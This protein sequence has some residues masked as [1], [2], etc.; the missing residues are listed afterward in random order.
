MNGKCSSRT[1]SF[2]MR[3]VLAILVALAILAGSPPAEAQSRRGGSSRHSS[4]GHSSRFGLWRSR[5]AD[6]IGRRTGRDIDLRGEGW[7]EP[8]PE[9]EKPEKGQ[10]R[11]RFVKW[12][13]GKDGRYDAL[14]IVLTDPEGKRTSELVVPNTGKVKPGQISPP[15]NIVDLAAKLK[16]GDEVAV[17]YTYFKRKY[18]VDSV[19]LHSALSAGDNAPFTFVRATEVKQGD[20][21]FLGVT[22]KR[23]KLIWTFLVPNEDVSAASFSG[24]DGKPLGEGT[25]NAPATRMLECLATVRNG[26]TISL[27]YSPDSYTFVLSD[28]RVSKIRSSGKF[29]RLSVRTVDGK[30]H[31]MAM[32]RVGTRTLSLVLP[33]SDPKKPNDNAARMAALLK[34]MR[35]WREVNFTYRRQ[36]GESWLDNVTIKP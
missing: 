36:D 1:K 13:K 10:A 11:A 14:S 32:F 4:R 31:Q 29:E 12:D 28:L 7:Q 15:A 20:R 9:P 3:A 34:D 35:Q 27:Q 22:A 16:I 33:L 23:N 8:E 26:D 17:N 25:I 30:R 2:H 21:K 19:K 24:P 5:I 6:E 18:T